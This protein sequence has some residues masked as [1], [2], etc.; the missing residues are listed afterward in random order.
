MRI[1]PI[2]IMLLVFFMASS[3]SAQTLSLPEVSKQLTAQAM[4]WYEEKYFP[5]SDILLEQAIIANPANDEAFSYLGYS[6]YQQK[7]YENAKRYFAQAISL[8]P[9]VSELWHWAAKTNL[10][11]GEREEAMDKLAHLQKICKKCKEITTLKSEIQEF[12]NEKLAKEEAEEKRLNEESIR[13]LN[14]NKEEKPSTSE[15]Q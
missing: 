8:T 14:E 13:Q 15:E 1:F 4:L 6:A 12:D 3:V 11:L 10:A 5:Q 9:S 2:Y 7:Y